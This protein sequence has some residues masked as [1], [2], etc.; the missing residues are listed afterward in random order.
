MCAPSPPP[1]PDYA[2]AAQAQGAANIDAARVQ[3]RINNP[4]VN[5]PTGT[6]TVTWD[7]DT[8]TLT[9][10]LSPEEQAIFNRNQ[11]NRQG[12]GDLAS[13]GIG[14]LQG[15]IGSQIDL[16]GAP[17]GGTPLDPNSIPR[18]TPL[19]PNSLPGMP[20]AYGGAQNMPELQNAEATRQRVIDA[21]MG[22]SNKAFAEREDQTNSDLIARGLRPGTEAYAREMTRIDQARN[23]ARQQAEIA[24]GDAAAQQFGMDLNRRKQLYG[25]G[26]TDANTIFDQG[27][28]IRRQAQGE[29]G[30]QFAQTGQ[31]G[32]FLQ[33]LQGQGFGQSQEARRQFITELLTRR[34]TPLN[35]I[36]ALMSGSQVNNPFAI[37]GYAQNTNVAPAPLFGAT[38]AQGAWD[39]NAY[40]QSVGSYNNMLSGI[41]GLGSAFLKPSDRRLKSNIRRV[42]THRLGF[43]VYAY[44][45]FGRPEVGVMADEVARVLPHAVIRY[46]D[47]YDRVN[48]AAL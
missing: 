48:Y 43:G 44:D 20:N 36:T 13:Q 24:G 42:G 10:T 27:M 41:F 34:Q 11:G 37:P 21:M 46:A 8:P 4:N 12:L 19:N 17:A 33:S 15:L 39:Q 45:I 14:S 40:N 31:L 16:S 2:G 18:G 35:E 9:Q 7:N 38:Q 30:Q 23:D 28:G 29:Q 32:Q 22:R 26:V 1:P 25:E 47:G 5:N 3:G 6:Q